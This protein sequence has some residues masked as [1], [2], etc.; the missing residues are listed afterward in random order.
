MPRNQAGAGER[1][2]FRAYIDLT[3]VVGTTLEILNGAS[4]GKELKIRRIQLAIGGAAQLTAKKTTAAASG[5]TSGA[6]TPSQART[7]DSAAATGK[8]YSVAPTTGTVECNWDTYNATGAAFWDTG[9]MN[10]ENPGCVIQQGQQFALFA[11]AAVTLK[12]FVE[13]WEDPV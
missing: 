2:C 5:G 11:S 12:G 1:S 4:S 13:Y 9:H 8:T 10:S 3:S 7:G 6:L